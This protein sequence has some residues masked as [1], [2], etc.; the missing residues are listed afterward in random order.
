MPA[1]YLDLLNATNDAF[2]Y[3]F[4]AAEDGLFV[5]LI[6]IRGST[7]RTVSSVTIQGGSPVTPIATNANNTRKYA[8]VAKEVTAGAVQ[9]VVTLSG[10]NGTTSWNLCAAWLLTNYVS[11][12]QTD[13]AVAANSGTSLGLT[14][15]IPANGIA[16][17]SAGHTHVGAE[18]HT[19]SAATERDDAGFSSGSTASADH[20]TG[21]AEPA[22]T[23]TV[24][25]AT[26]DSYIGLAV[27]WEFNSSADYSMDADAGSFTL[28][29]V[30][31]G[32]GMDLSMPALAGS[33]ILTG[34]SIVIGGS[35]AM[36]AGTASFVMTGIAAALARPIFRARSATVAAKAA[37]H[38]AAASL[39][40]LRSQ[41]ASLF[42]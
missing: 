6:E 15:D 24:S 11:T 31:I 8:I 20:S 30:N 29:G 4:T 34:I 2:T 22:H 26:S 33:F 38:T 16:L 17:Y 42:K 9:V 14:L 13:F 23:E 18:D 40:K 39:R 7:A 5:A 32:V 41:A 21:A 36:I 12:T 35:K 37:V 3:N 1:T 27:S 25:W 19:W 28:T 10:T